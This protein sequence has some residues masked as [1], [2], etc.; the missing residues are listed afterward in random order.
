MKCIILAAG[1][2]KRM[3]PLTASRPK[4]MIPVANRPMAEYLLLAVRDAGI[5]EFVF[6]VG[7]QE[8]AIRDHFGNGSR[9]GVT[10]DYV[11]QR[12][13]RGTGDALLAAE[14]LTGDRFLLANGD[15]IVDSSDVSAIISSESP[16]V[17]IFESERP[18]EY[19]VVTVEEG[20]IRDLAEKSPNPPSNR[21]NAG[22]YLFQDDI[23]GLLRGLPLSARGEYELTDALAQYIAGGKLRA[24]QLASWMDMGSPW[25]LLDANARLLG[26]QSD[27]IEGV[28]S[29]SAYVQGPLVL[30]ADSIVLPGTVI[31]GPCIIGR[32][33]RIGP[34]A[35][36]RGSTA[37][38]DGCHIGHCTEIKNSIIMTGTKAPHFNYIGDSVIG[39]GC[40][41]GAGTKIANLRHDNGPVTVCGRNTGRRKFGAVIGDD[42]LFGINCSVNVGALI[43][44]SS[45]V[46]PHSFVSGCFGAD[47]FIGR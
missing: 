12:R 28:V 26:M 8:K 22:I 13:Q 38:G 16:A 41:F 24:C 42:V 1:E 7:Y 6:V 18:G 15:M 27:V 14:G 20:M 30:G 4:V 39:S 40:N 33:C 19:G 35:H 11:T 25:D 9:F 43:G 10:I 45:R 31:E 34:N 5:S 23:F 29:P 21:I 46:A 44:S 47:S 3:R 2:G 37:I 36:I 17:G 32:N